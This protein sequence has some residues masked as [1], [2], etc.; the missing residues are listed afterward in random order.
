MSEIFECTFYIT[1]QPEEAP[2]GI[3]Y[4]TE[5]PISTLDNTADLSIHSIMNKVFE[6]EE[7]D[8]DQS[9]ELCSIIG[10]E[11]NKVTILY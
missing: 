8:K 3:Y 10:F 6:I 2:L 11:N 4:L 7:I 5:I 1:W 9:Y